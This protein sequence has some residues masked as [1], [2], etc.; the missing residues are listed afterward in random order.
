MFCSPL[1]FRFDLEDLN[2]G[3]AHPFQESC[4]K[5]ALNIER[6]VY[7][8][9][10]EKKFENWSKKL[11]HEGGEAIIVNGVAQ[12]IHQAFGLLLGELLT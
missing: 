2:V 5:E 6:D 9:T 10:C 7:T 4:K 8:Y 1:I 11:T 12:L 3:L